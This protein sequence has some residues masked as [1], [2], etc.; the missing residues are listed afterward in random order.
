MNDGRRGKPV[1]VSELLRYID[2]IT[3]RGHSY[4][5]FSSLPPLD[6]P[7]TMALKAFSPTLL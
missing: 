7:V 6:T 1:V 3:F 4:C 5:Y 2:V